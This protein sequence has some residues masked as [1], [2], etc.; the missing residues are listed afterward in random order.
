MKYK[1]EILETLRR[2]VE[3]E[4]ESEEEAIDK[5]KTMY[6]KADIVLDSSDFIG[7]D[8]QIIKEQYDVISPDG[9]S[10]SRDVVYNSLKEAENA[11]EEWKKRY[12]LQG[13]YSSNKGKIPLDE[14]KEHCKII[15][16]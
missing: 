11:F 3:V 8:Y 7:V 9:F 14:L 15:E 5:I 16:I 1:V 13:Y 6:G 10:I 2:E 12:I 4:S